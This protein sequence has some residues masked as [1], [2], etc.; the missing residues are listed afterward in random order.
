MQLLHISAL[1][2]VSFPLPGFNIWGC[3]KALQVPSH[4]PFPVS[5]SLLH[6]SMQIPALCR[7]LLWK[8]AKPANRSNKQSILLLCFSLLV[9][10]LIPDE[11]VS[12]SSSEFVTAAGCPAGLTQFKHCLLLEKHHYPQ[13]KGA[14]SW[15]GG[16]SPSPPPSD[17]SSG[18]VCHR[19]FWLGT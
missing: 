19:C 2:H 18:S 15:K 9:V 4:L 7:W 1:L 6:S 5:W 8:T 3:L 12:H 10:L 17:A 16:L 13:V 14:Q 11:W